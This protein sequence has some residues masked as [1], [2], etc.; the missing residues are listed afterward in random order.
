[1]DENQ[2]VPDTIFSS[3]PLR[4]V[5]HFNEKDSIPQQLTTSTSLLT[6]S[7]TIPLPFPLISQKPGVRFKLFCLLLCLIT[8]LTIGFILSLLFITQIIRMPKPNFLS[9]QFF[10]KSSEQ[11]AVNN[12]IHLFEHFNP[13][14][15]DEL[16]FST[17][18][19]NDFYGFI[20][21]KWL[22]NHPLSPLELKRSWLTERSQ[23]IRENFAEKLA[24]ASEIEA[25]NYRTK[26]DKNNTQESVE[27]TTLNYFD[28]LPSD[29][30]E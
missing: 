13:L 29:K 16:D 3:S 27:D 10:S 15:T 9:Y 17:D 1:M 26:A 30:N 5:V 24:N 23:N 11:N 28:G 19:C 14:W 20:C 21:R 2:D 6:S 12:K 22:S 7:S 25:Y 8:A 4:K 18:I